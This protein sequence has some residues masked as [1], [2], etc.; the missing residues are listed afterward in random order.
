[1]C[2]SL[3]LRNTEMKFGQREFA[4]CSKKFRWTRAVNLVACAGEPNMPRGRKNALRKRHVGMGKRAASRRVA[5]QK[6]RG[7]DHARPE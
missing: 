3:F 7:T 1:M 5:L 6:Q 4:Q 2:S